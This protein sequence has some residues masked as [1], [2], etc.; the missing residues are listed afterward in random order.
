MDFE[1]AA[2]FAGKGEVLVVVVMCTGE[3][4]A[5]VLGK[6]RR[7]DGDVG[8]A[9]AAVLGKEGAGAMYLTTPPPP[10]G[11]PSFMRE[12]EMEE[13][14]EVALSLVCVMEMEAGGECS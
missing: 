2:A 5:E 13:G 6:V 3:S 8:G 1:G 4:E 7:C 9:G 10:S 11:L 12:M 14:G